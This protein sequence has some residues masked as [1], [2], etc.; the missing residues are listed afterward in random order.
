MKILAAGCLHND[1]GL[2]RKLAKQAE[3]EDVD[4]VVLC[5]DL[6]LGERS[7]DY[8]V[9]PFVKRNKKV[10]IVPGNHETVATADF[11]AKKYG[12]TNLHGYSKLFGDIG[13]FGCG[14]ANCG[15]FQLSEE[16][17]FSTLYKAHFKIKDAEKRIMVT[18]VHP[19]ETM[20]ERFSG[21]VRGSSGVTEAIEKLKPDLLLC[22]H[23]HEAAGIEETLGETKIVNVSKHGNIIEL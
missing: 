16:D 6:T 3:D 12:V 2:V 15:V 10:V 5:G 21:F 13:F 11:L 19:A 7:T 14:G 23:V 17:I 18:H 4:L 22:S 8:I 1:T 20:M 9:G